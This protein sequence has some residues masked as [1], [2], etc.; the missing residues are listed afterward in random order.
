MID[1][2][3]LSPAQVRQQEGLPPCTRASLQAL[4]QAHVS[5]PRLRP[6]I[7]WLNSLGW[8]I[9]NSNLQKPDA[10]GPAPG[11]SI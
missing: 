11:A 7:A 3:L 5:D 6:L 1:V 2:V 9:E 10:S 8:T 4:L